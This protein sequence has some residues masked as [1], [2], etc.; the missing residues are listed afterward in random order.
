MNSKASDQ[1]AIAVLQLKTELLHVRAHC[2]A[3]ESAIV[4]VA[5]TAD[6]P[7]EDLRRGIDQVKAGVLQTLLEQIEA[8]DP[9]LA[10]GLDD[11]PTPPPGL[12][13]V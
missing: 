8:A 12:P 7:E 13:E 10:A 11:R 5:R 6:I 9:G 2:A 4:V 1:L 3:L